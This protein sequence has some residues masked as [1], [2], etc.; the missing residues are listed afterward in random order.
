MKGKIIQL[1]SKFDPDKDYGIHIR[2]QIRFVLKLLEPN[3]EYVLAELIKKYN[4]TI[5][6]NGNIENTRN[7]FKHVVNTG[8]S[9]KILEEIQVEPIT[10]EEFCK[11]PT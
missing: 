11:I 8:K 6:R 3:I 1:T 7:V 10:F 2:K 5:S 4:L 9:I